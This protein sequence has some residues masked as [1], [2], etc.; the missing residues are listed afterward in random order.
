MP[1]MV[2]QHV[3]LPEPTSERICGQSGVIDATKPSNQDQN[4]QRTVQD[5][6]EVDKTASQER[7]SERTGE[8]I[9]VIEVPK[10]ASQESVEVFKS[11]PQEQISER[12]CEQSEVIEVT[13]ISG[14]VEQILDDT[15]HEPISRISERI[16]ELN[17]IFVTV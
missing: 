12:M 17:S 14:T 5:S 3:V 8:R 7:I 16:R 9:R 1:K 6:V 11:T 15:R 10:I 13:E 2:S 4:L